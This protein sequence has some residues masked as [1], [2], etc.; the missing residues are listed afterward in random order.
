MN[1][2]KQVIIIAVNFFETKIF[3]II[4]FNIIIALHLISTVVAMF[5]GLDG[6]GFAYIIIYGSAIGT[7]ILAILY[8]WGVIDGE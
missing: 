5:I 7:I 1:I 4:I 2:I 6:F 3:K 8:L